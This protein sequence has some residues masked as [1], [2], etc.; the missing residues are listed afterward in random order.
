[1][2]GFTLVEILISAAILTVLIAG[3]FM[4][5][6]IGQRSW[7]ADM[8]WLDLQQ[9]ARQAM[10]GMVREIR[11]S[12]SSDIAITGAPPRIQFRIPTDITTQP[13]IYSADISYY[14][15]NNQLIR[16]HPAGTTKILANDINALNFSLSD[17]ELSLSIALE[18]R[19]SSLNRVLTFPLSE[20]V[21][22]RND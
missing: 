5:L 9:Q 16:E 14:L 22:L 21:R 13:I 7:N 18:A 8:G 20:K 11:Q 10:A 6:N 3:V 17:D 2:K 19:K 1:M 15:S 4:V 12:K